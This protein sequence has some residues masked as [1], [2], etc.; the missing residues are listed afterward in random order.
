MSASLHVAVVDTFALLV[1]VVDTFAFLVGVVLLGAVHI[2]CEDTFALIVDVLLCT[3]L[4][5]LKLS[6]VGLWI[7]LFSL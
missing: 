7:L 2:G 1:G 4:Y 3:H 5:L 6:V